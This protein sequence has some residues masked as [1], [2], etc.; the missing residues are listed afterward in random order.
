MNHRN[1]ILIELKEISPTLLN[2]KEN[3]KPLVIPADYFEQLVNS[4][5]AETETESSFLSSI[6]KEKTEVP[7]NYFD[8]FGDS[9]FTKIKEQEKTIKQGK[10]IEFPKQ[11]AKIYRIFKR[12]TIAASVVAVVFFMKQVQQPNLPINDCTD[13][14]ACLTQEEIY[15]YLNVNSHEFGTEQIKKAVQD[16]IETTE[17][18]SIS[19]NDEELNTYLENNTLLLDS[20]DAYTDIF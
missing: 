6:K 20:E 19:V 2:L 7:I 16:N 18:S 12:V 10:I 11:S 5:L 3:E 13:G 9:I 14:I 4:C 8:T 17:T 15:N 1:D